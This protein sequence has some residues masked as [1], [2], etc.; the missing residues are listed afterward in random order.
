[1]EVAFLNLKKAYAELKN[2]LDHV[3]QELHNDGSYILGSRLEKFEKEFAEYLGVKHVI[4][5]ANGLDALTLSLNALG[6]GAGDEMIVPAH[7]FIASWLAISECGAIPVPV[8]VNMKD[9][10]LDTSKI[11]VAITKRTRAIMPVHL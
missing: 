7:T 10:L 3:W 4:G 5:V 11:E 2:D 8:E 9:Y 6:I 1:M